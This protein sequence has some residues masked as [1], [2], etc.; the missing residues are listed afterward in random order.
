MGIGALVLG[1]VTLTGAVLRSSCVALNADA[2]FCAGFD[3]V[4]RTRQLIDEDGEIFAAVVQAVYHPEWYRSLAWPY[5]AVILQRQT[6]TGRTY[7]GSGEK[8]SG[9]LSS[10]G[11]RDADRLT[12]LYR[13]AN[14]E[15]GL[16]EPIRRNFAQ[17]ILLDSIQSMQYLTGVAME[18]TTG[19]LPA[20]E[21]NLA[22]VL[23]TSR[24]AY[25]LSSS[26]AAMF[27]V[28][29]MPRRI[30]SAVGDSA[31]LVLLQRRSGRWKVKGEAAVREEP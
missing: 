9:M 8:L 27:V 11:A 18:D 10:L 5:G 26:E 22:P 15:P 21:S 1:D 24:A 6:T 17:Q 2:P 14:R 12:M 20:F 19:A 29:R 25:D 4:P 30:G 16:V 23:V 28:L 7:L 3:A 13:A 31:I